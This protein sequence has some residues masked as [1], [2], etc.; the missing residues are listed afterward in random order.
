MNSDMIVGQFRR[1]GGFVKTFEAIP[2]AK[3]NLNDVLVAMTAE[4]ISPP[5]SHSLFCRLLVIK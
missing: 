3:N 5:S 4:G 2:A 1:G